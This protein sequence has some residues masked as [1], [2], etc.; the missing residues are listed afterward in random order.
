MLGVKMLG[1]GK[2]RIKSWNITGIH[3]LFYTWK[4]Q[5]FFLDTVGSEY[6]EVVEGR[7]CGWLIGL[8]G[9]FFSTWRSSTAATFLEIWNI[10][11]IV[12]Y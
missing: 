6:E 2:I 11:C 7:K 3:S 12:N 1:V 9:V 5:T 8:F 10:I 4:M